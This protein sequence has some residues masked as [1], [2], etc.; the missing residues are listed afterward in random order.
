M[1]MVRFSS[2]GVPSAYLN[3]T[4]KLCGVGGTR[5]PVIAPMAFSATPVTY[6]KSSSSNASAKG[7]RLFPGETCLFLLLA[8]E[9]LTNWLSGPQSG[10]SSP[11]SPSQIVQAGAK[12]LTPHG[13]LWPSPP[14]FGRDLNPRK[15]LQFHDSRPL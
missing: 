8:G 1:S 3:Q 11:R 2:T 12:A 7:V 13:L 5:C 15:P 10:P 6:S 14:S 4:W 9:G